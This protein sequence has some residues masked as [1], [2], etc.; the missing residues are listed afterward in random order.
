MK[1][2][3]LLA[4]LISFGGYSQQL[5]Y[6]TGGK[7]F[8]S[9][10]KKIKP[11]T[12]RELMKGNSAALTLYNTGRKKKTWG[13]VLF[14][15]GLGLGAVN[16]ITALS[17]DYGEV[18]PTGTYSYTYNDK[19]TSPALAIV[20]GVMVLASIPIKLGYTSKVKSALGEY[21]NDISYRESTTPEVSLLAN[22]Q[23]LGFRLIF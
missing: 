19:K 3:F 11:S 6:G 13:N 5:K 1:K 17:S 14:Y 4:I 7:V 23:G 10:D 9:E 21:N 22:N 18:T 12:V 8:D 2:L 20:G 16:L 15:G